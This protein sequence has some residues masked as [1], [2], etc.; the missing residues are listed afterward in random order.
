MQNLQQFLM[1]A[2]GGVVFLLIITVLVA[3]HEL[4]HYWVARLC[5]MHVKAFAIM[6][7]GRRVTDLSPRLKRSLAPVSALWA[8]GLA[9]FAMVLG[10]GYGNV[11]ILYSVGLALMGVVV[12]AWIGLRIG[13]LYHLGL[14]PTLKI[15]GLSWAA[16]IVVLMMASRGHF[17]PNQVLFVLG[18]ASVIALMILYYQPV[19]KK[20]EDD[21][22]GDGVL[23]ID[24]EDVPVQFRP[25]LSRTSK[26]GTEFSLLLLPLGG[27]AAIKGM[28]P[29]NDAS[30][31]EVDGGFYSKS[32]L[33]RLAVLFAGPLFSILFGIVLFVVLFASIGQPKPDLDPV[34]GTVVKD[35]A[36]EKA[37]LKAGDR[38]VS[39]NGEKVDSFYQ[40]LCIIRDR[41][42]EP[43][44]F[45]YRREGKT[46]SVVITPGATPEPMPILGPDLE[47]TEVEKIQGKIGVGY[48]RKMV[49]LSFAAAWAEAW[50]LPKELVSGLAKVAKQPSKAKEQLGGPGTI[51]AAAVD[52]TAQGLG[53][54][55]MLAAGLSLS[56]GVMNLLPIVP[57]DGGQMVIAFVEL[58]R[59][60]KRLSMQVQQM[61]TQV[62]MLLVFA[63]MIG[64]IALDVSRFVGPKEK[65]TVSAPL[66]KTE[67]QAAPTEAKT[68]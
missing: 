4:G 28:A 10:G 14:G 47:P 1:Y 60:G 65:L 39:V 50:S 68:P 34:I 52:V 11:P 64:V 62:G 33:K 20:G 13:A 40:M 51:A 8:S 61:V 38:V 26:S 32:P 17:Q 48:K 35:E 18:Y 21:E 2:L 24:G 63:L 45:V 3:V 66:P 5:G 36:A 6:M 42:G 67:K 22:M 25:L 53:M 56:L 23:P 58:L 7:G 54:I 59:G 57:L 12:P 55:L 19:A 27:F 16:G 31:T 43:T 9:G 41:A 46:Q 49:R 37:G 29:K 30:E 15:L 44:E